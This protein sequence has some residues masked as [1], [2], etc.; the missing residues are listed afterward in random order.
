MKDVSFLFYFFYWL[1]GNLHLKKMRKYLFTTCICSLFIICCVTTKAQSVSQ[2][3]L[4]L[5]TKHC[6]QCHGEDGTRG[7]WGARNLQTTNLGDAAL[8]AVISNGRGIMPRWSKK[9]DQNQIDALVRYIKTL[10]RH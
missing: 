5:F 1:Q 4:M 2:P 7:R 3:A 8:Q 9:F 10:R 6:V